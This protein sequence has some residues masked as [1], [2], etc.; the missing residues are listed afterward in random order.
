MGTYLS[1]MRQF[2]AIEDGEQEYRLQHQP[3]SYQ[4]IKALVLMMIDNEIYAKYMLAKRKEWKWWD[5]WLDSFCHRPTYVHNRD[6][7]RM[8]AAKTAFFEEKYVPFLK[9]N[10]IECSTRNQVM[11]GNMNQQGNMYAGNMYNHQRENYFPSGQE[12][13]Q[14]DEDPEDVNAGAADVEVVRQNSRENDS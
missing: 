6:N 5:T 11:N 13:G 2:I 9:E 4:S 8:L 7:E 10:G 1:I 14:F 3:F 12:P